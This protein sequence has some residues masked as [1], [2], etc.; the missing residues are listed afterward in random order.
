MNNKVAL[1][2]V[3]AALA[4]VLIYN[5][6]EP[7]S[8][9]QLKVIEQVSKSRLSN[10]F[11]NTM[12]KESIPDSTLLTNE[13]PRYGNSTSSTTLSV[14]SQNQENVQAHEQPADQFS[15]QQPKAHG[16]ENQRR[17]REDNSLIPPGEPKKP[18][19]NQDNNG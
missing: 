5:Q 12:N 6:Q 16:H 13:E 8:E 18:L 17:N 7:A 2:V 9:L 15:G 1:G 19:P 14:S 3:C 10:T 4:T 11:E